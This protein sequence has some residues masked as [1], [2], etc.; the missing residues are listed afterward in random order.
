MI[1]E[2]VGAEY[3][4][5]EDGMGDSFFDRAVQRPE[6]AHAVNSDRLEGLTRRLTAP[7]ARRPTP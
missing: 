6:P 2:W 7:V 4:H 5:G 3:V 1:A